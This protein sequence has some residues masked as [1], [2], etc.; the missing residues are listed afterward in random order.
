MLLNM[1]EQVLLGL[2]LEGAMHGYELYQALQRRVGLVYA[3]NHVTQLYPFLRK[4]RDRGWVAERVEI[5]AG[6][7]N[8]HVYE[9][10]DRGREEFAAWLTR[11]VA[12]RREIRDEFLAK[13]CFSSTV[14]PARTLALL[15]QQIA[16]YAAHKAELEAARARAEAAGLLPLVLAAESGIRHSQT[17]IDWATWCKAEIA[18]RTPG[19][20]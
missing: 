9:I 2:L 1:I 4:M 14:D 6:R 15:D 19:G 13:L 7:P 12:G 16:L 11:P 8:R 5:Q 17:D 3:V 20:A 10:T 18:R